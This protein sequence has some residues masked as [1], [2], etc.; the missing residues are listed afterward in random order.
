MS[1]NPDLTSH[2]SP[3]KLF[4]IGAISL[5]YGVWEFHRKKRLL[6][7]WT[8]TVGTVDNIRRDDRENGSI[9]IKYVDAR[10]QKQAC[11]LSVADSDR[12]G[13]GTQ[14][15]IAYNP[16]APGEAFVADRKDMTLTAIIAV[17][18]GLLALAASGM[19][20]IQR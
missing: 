15:K 13:L 10:G 14:L 18:I 17:V 16:H 3:T 5:G 2:F 7:T 4:L 6:A 19:L 8:A 12:V 1:G 20:A 9:R 11:W